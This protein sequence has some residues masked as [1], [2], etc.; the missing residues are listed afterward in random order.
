MY[1]TL[2]QEIESEITLERQET[3]QT[4]D[5]ISNCPRPLIIEQNY[6]NIKIFNALDDKL[7]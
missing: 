3:F 4:R 2:K 7:P 1:K 5:L 6:K